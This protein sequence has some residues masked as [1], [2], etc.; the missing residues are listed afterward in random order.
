[1]RLDADSR[2]WN[3]QRGIN[4][5]DRQPTMLPGHGSR[6]SRVAGRQ[7]EHEH[8]AVDA[9][10]GDELQRGYGGQ[11]DG[12]KGN[13]QPHGPPPRVDERV[14]QRRASPGL[15]HLAV[16]I[17][18]GQWQGGGHLD[19]AHEEIESVESVVGAVVVE[20]IEAHSGSDQHREEHVVQA[21]LVLGKQLRRVG[22]ARGHLPTQPR[23]QR[24]VALVCRA[25][26][27]SHGNL[28]VPT[29]ARLTPL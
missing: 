6:I 11:H 4:G 17:R 22:G 9:Q 16:S 23:L 13:A 5:A 14:T 27:E 18:R 28:L 25:I 20:I 24:H 29:S 1:M 8:A 3:K 19:I 7:V 12:D 10:L 21:F 26:V 15:V 2:A